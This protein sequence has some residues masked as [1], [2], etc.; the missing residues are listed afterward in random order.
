MTRVSYNTVAVCGA[1]SSGK[2][3]LCGRLITDMVTGCSVPESSASSDENPEKYRILTDRTKP[4]IRLGYSNMTSY[5]SLTHSSDS[6]ELICIPGSRKYWKWVDFGLSDSDSMMVVIKPDATGEV[7][8]SELIE[9]IITGVSFGISQYLIVVNNWMEL[10]STVISSVLESIRQDLIR[11]FRTTERV[12]TIPILEVNRSTESIVAL[13]EMMFKS[14][15]PC[16]PRD[17]SSAFQLSINEVR[18]VNETL[19]VGGR[20]LTGSVSVGDQV[21]LMPSVIP[22]RV[23]SIHVEG[24]TAACTAS[25]G[26]VAGLMLSGISEDH[27]STGMALVASEVPASP[28]RQIEVEVNF[29]NTKTAVKVGA[30]PVLSI[31]SVQ[32]HCRIASMDNTSAELGDTVTCHLVLNKTIFATV[33]D[34]EH[35]S[36]FSRVRLRMDNVVVAI[37]VVKRILN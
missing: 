24:K 33:F 8:L 9:P 13:R 32:A 14:L 21:V 25:A 3:V 17:T 31:L 10:P 30:S 22:L 18:S 35:P 4:E 19:V 16:F 20:V 29:F 2:S 28:A 23:E 7:A 36:P 27:V 15:S 37:G 12:S 6:C 34:K 1:A 11:I 26:Q 5:T